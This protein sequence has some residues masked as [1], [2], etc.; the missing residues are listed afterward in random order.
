M[1]Q[2]RE[3]TFFFKKFAW[4]QDNEEVKVMKD[5]KVSNSRTYMGI[6]A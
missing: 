2:W 5:H 6:F 4:F 1:E 3:N